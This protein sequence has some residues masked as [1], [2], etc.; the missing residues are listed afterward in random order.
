MSFLRAPRRFPLTTFFLLA[1]GWTWLCWW[2]VAAAA[3][4]RLSLPVPAERLATLGQFGPF[5]AAVAV[6]LVTGGGAGLRDL[7][8]RLVRWRAR[9]AWV[10]VSL[11]LLPA[12][13]LLAIALHASVN[14]TFGSLQ[15][16]E[17]WPTLPAHFVYTLL[18]CGPLG[19][20]PG[21]RGFAL[22]RLQERCGPVA[23]SVLLG[24]LGS[25]WHLPLWWMYPAPCPFPLF[26]AGGVLLTFLFTWLFNHT[27]G[28]AF[29][30]L[31]FH[32]S[33]STAS[34]RLPAA[35]AYHYWVPILGGL[36]LAILLRDGRLGRRRDDAPGREGPDATGEDVRNAPLDPG[37]V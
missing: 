9:P 33:L 23:A 35:P 27:G 11:L 34:V 1:Y 25:F 30:S 16:R 22:P 28:S 15:F 7:L 14:G 19:E 13:M 26:V 6:A 4:G 3:A 17:A 29:Y 8:G 20:E 12:T 37:V 36:V 24:L 18:L 21:W 31:V 10:A 5:F 32:A 2:P